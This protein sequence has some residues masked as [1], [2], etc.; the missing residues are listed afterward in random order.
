IGLATLRFLSLF[1]LSLLLLAPLLKVNKTYYEKPI[2]LWLE[3]NSKS[4]LLGAKGE[5]TKSWF[6]QNRD[7]YI[8]A[9]SEKYDV[10]IRAFGAD[11]TLPNDSFPEVYSN[12]GLALENGQ[13]QFYNQNISGVVLLSDGIY[14]QGLNPLYSA[15]QS[16]IPIYTVGF[17][18]TSV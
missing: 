16:S 8:K 17:G 2:L 3:D 5:E 6:S 4:M 9:L 12:I 14:N 11:I 13:E 10:N 7:A 15:Q 18:D 1:I